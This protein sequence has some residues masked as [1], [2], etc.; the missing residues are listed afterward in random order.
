MKI[1]S[2]TATFGKLEQQTLTLQPGLNIIEAPNEWGK[3]TWCAFLAAMLY[4][5][6]TRTHTTKNALADKERYAPW[7][8]APMSGRMEL[9]WQGRDITIERKTK[10]RLIFGDFQTYETATG[11]A[12]PELTAANCGQLLLGVE[13]SVFLRSGF[14]RQENMPVTEDEALRRRLNALVT[15][16]DESGAA[17]TLEKK[18]RELKNACR[19]N[20]TGLLP[21]AQAQAQALEHQ[22]AQLADAQQQ[23]RHLTAEQNRLEQ[24]QSQLT[25]HEAALHHA[26][27]QENRKRIAA[28][29]AEC[30]KAAQ[31]VDTLT[32]TCEAL[33]SAD[34]AQAQLDQ[35]QTLQETFLS[36]QLQRQ[37][38]DAAPFQGL[39]GEEA[40]QQARLDRQRY[41]AL[42]AKAK[43]GF[44]VWLLGLPLLAAGGALFYFQYFLY[45]Y[46]ALGLGAGLALL[47]LILG[48]RRRYQNRR[49]AAQIQAIYG[50]MPASQWEALAQG[51][52]AQKTWQER[53]AHA[54]QAMED[55]TQRQ[56]PLA[57]RE[58]LQNALTQWDALAAAREQLARLEAFRDSLGQLPTQAQP[59]EFP[60]RLTL[61]L[62][63]TQSL[64]RENNVRQHRLQQQLGHCM[65]QMTQLGQESD[66]RQ[67]LDALYR[68]IRQLEDSYAALTLA[69]NTLKDATVELQRRFAPQITRRAQQLFS[70]MTAGRYDRLTL[71]EDFRIH[72]ATLE[73]NTLHSAH[74]RSEGTADQ[75]YLALRL[76]VSEALTPDAP[77]VLDDALVRFDDR[78]LAAVLKILQ[79]E[80]RHKQVLLFTCQSREKA[81]I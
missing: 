46:I 48:L 79:E 26:A 36:L 68:R 14:I 31:D 70:Q 54:R 57:F 63:E 34:A 19:Y 50:D 49:A 80:A 76:S 81:L 35:F 21:Q 55:L 73:E 64:L 67:R 37:D 23:L 24:Q 78:R 53:L 30:R 43:G 47:G 22:L 77:L 44:P 42:T 3:S 75:L 27:T 41:E 72:A 62:A 17:D 56:N 12:V 20:K 58:H 66:L 4:G 7:S 52:Q 6:E 51:Y 29:E 9:E 28:A 39:T 61:S 11:I 45:S 8:G 2:M 33:P 5:L 38:A 32:Q 71:T 69:Q 65:G 15:T 60:D 25:N 16:G 59:P 40:V 10:G 74:F 1:Y 13:R 18:L